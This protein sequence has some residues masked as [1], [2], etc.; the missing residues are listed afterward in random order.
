MND[1]GLFL[2]VRHWWI[3]LGW[4]W[5]IH[6]CWDVFDIKI[7]VPW[8]GQQ[9]LGRWFWLGYWMILQM[10]FLLLEIDWSRWSH[11]RTCQHR[12]ERGQEVDDHNR[13]IE[14]YVVSSVQ[15][16]P[17]PLWPYYTNT[18]AIVLIHKRFWSVKGKFLV[19]IR[20]SQEGVVQSIVLLEV[21]TVAKKFV[22]H[23]L[24]L[25]GCNVLWQWRWIVTIQLVTKQVHNN[26][27]L[28][29][30]EDKGLQ[31]LRC[32]TCNVWDC[33]FHLVLLL[34]LPL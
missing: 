1:G 2:I 33:H 11:Q 17:T 6:D 10:S 13:Y 31:E 24:T 25:E 34:R 15:E 12:G 19:M 20:D 7:T 22:K 26:L 30:R 32:G 5:Q 14:Y 27:F 21:R 16:I 28:S 9:C 4:F 23:H 3:F 8:S 29:I 18:K